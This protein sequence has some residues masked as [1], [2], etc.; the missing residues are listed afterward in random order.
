MGLGAGLNAAVAAKAHAASRVVITDIR[1]DNF[2]VA[3]QVQCP[4][5]PQQ[6]ASA[7]SLVSL[8]VL[9]RNAVASVTVCI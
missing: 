2:A 9:R 6:A 4:V 7:L 3:E 1:P 8:Q 5:T